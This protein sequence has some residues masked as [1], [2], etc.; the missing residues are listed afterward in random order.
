MPDTQQNWVKVP[1][2]KNTKNNI[3]HTKCYFKMHIM[4][5]T[6]LSLHATYQCYPVHRYNV[7]SCVHFKT[8]L[9]P[10]FDKHPVR[11]CRQ[12][13]TTVHGV[14]VTSFSLQYQTPPCWRYVAA[15]WRRK[16]TY[17]CKKVESGIIHQ[18]E[19]T[20]RW[21]KECSRFLHFS[22]ACVHIKNT[23]NMAAWFRV[24]FNDITAPY[25]FTN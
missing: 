16:F 17:A 13:C 18:S 15:V 22:A 4:H 25:V 10:I 2:Q 1:I 8:R 7:S 14:I 24:Q 9:S 5:V 12:F 6:S 21:A 11:S 3:K 19:N 23:S 20:A